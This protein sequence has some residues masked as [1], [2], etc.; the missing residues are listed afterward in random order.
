MFS[1]RLIEELKL[2]LKSKDALIQCLKEEKSQMASPDEAV[3]S[4]ELQG[5]SA[6]LRG[7]REGEAEVRRRH[8]AGG[9]FNYPSRPPSGNECISIPEAHTHWPSKYQVPVVS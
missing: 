2:S 4:G 5:L 9:G 7:D 8:T 1:F 3:S 6:A